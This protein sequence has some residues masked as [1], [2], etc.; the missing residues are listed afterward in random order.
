MCFCWLYW[1]NFSWRHWIFFFLLSTLCS[2]RV[3]ALVIVLSDCPC[4]RTENRWLIRFWKRTDSWCAFSW[5][6][7]DKTVTLLGVSRA[8]VM[9][10]Y[11][12]HEKTT[13]A[14]RNSGR[15]ST[16]KERDRRT[17]W[18]MVSKLLQQRWQDSRTEYSS[19]STCF[20]KNCPTWASQIQHPWQ[21]CNC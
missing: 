21:G 2:A 3:S 16:L 4:E 11:T 13:S 15:K 5:S 8:K 14:K 20:H 17:L 1:K 10:A 18:R 7:C 6:I 9:S 19:G 12:N